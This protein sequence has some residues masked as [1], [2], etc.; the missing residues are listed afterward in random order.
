M[1]VITL[2]FLTCSTYSPLLPLVAAVA[3]GTFAM[4]DNTRNRTLVLRVSCVL[5]CSCADERLH[6]IAMQRH[7]HA[8]VGGVTVFSSRV[9]REIQRPC[10]G[11]R[12]DGE[13][14]ART[15]SPLPGT[16]PH[17]SSPLFRPALRRSW[18][19]MYP[20][21]PPTL[22]TCM[23]ST[24]GWPVLRERGNWWRGPCFIRLFVSMQAARIIQR[25]WR[26]SHDLAKRAV[27]QAKAKA[28]NVVRA[29]KSLR[30]AARSMKLDGSAVRPK[31]DK[32]EEGHHPAD[33]SAV[34]GAEVAL[35]EL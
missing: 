25:H 18:L 31:D 35:T 24:S 6:G 5:L 21:K 7:S 2:P 34:V 11:I 15:S 14:D 32:K 3:A 9:Q 27:R 8:S 1:R 13:Q 29:L 30:L 28:K 20:L 23:R 22:Q 10:Q 33:V 19:L 16:G 26:G 12:E 17:L 4:D